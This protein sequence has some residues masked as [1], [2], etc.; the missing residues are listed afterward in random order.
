MII[1][2]LITIPLANMCRQAAPARSNAQMPNG[3]FRLQS[4]ISTLFSFLFFFRL[5][6][7][8]DFHALASFAAASKKVYQKNGTFIKNFH[9]EGEGESANGEIAFG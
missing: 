5:G 1:I 4:A 6:K 9:V 3:P 7:N 8:R 2:R